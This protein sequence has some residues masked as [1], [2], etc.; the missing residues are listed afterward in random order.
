MTREGYGQAYQHGFDKTIRF[1]RSRGVAPDLAGD[2]AQAAWV[3]GWER[4]SQLRN[5][6]MVTTWV[7]AIAINVYRSVLRR[8]KPTAALDH[9]ATRAELNV[10]AIDVVRILE[11]CTPRDRAL[12]E[13]QLEGATAGEIAQKHGVTVSAVRIRLLRARRTVRFQAEKKPALPRRANENHRE[14]QTQSGDLHAT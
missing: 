13:L 10:A 4:L 11:F 9:L 5:E 2:V 12:L 8:E 3:K 6:S 1:L 14:P 7:N